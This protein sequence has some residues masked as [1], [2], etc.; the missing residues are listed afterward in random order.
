[1]YTIDNLEVYVIIL[2]IQYMYNILQNIL[3]VSQY[4]KIDSTLHC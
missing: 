4:D 2:E 1:V 3:S